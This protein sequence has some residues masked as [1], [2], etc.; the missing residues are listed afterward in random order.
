MDSGTVPSDWRD[1]NITPIYKKGRNT[2]ELNY[3][4]VTKENT[5][6]MQRNLGQ[7]EEWS[8]M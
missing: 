4:P 1:A 6:A 8:N 2:Q 7:L 5:E 3:R